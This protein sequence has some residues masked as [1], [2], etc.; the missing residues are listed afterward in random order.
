MRFCPISSI[1]VIRHHIPAMVV[2]SLI[3]LDSSAACAQQIPWTEVTPRPPSAEALKSL[4]PQ[5]GSLLAPVFLVQHDHYA[6]GE[7]ILVRLGFKNTS[8]HVIDIRSG[9]PPWDESVMSIIGPDGRTIPAGLREI[10]GDDGSGRLF[11]IGPGATQ[12]ITWAK[13]DWYP[14]DHWSYHLTSPGIY[15]IVVRA[16]AS[17][18]NTTNV[19][20]EQS[21]TATLTIGP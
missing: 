8:S 10:G 14:L 21:T 7:P 5:D 6:I 13:Q 11:S 20:R 3:W 18:A 2:L 9:A 4:P 15:H 17:G 16:L 1:R 12:F 19:S